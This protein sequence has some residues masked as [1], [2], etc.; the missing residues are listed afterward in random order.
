MRILSML[1]QIMGQGIIQASFTG[2]QRH[3]G[4]TP[5]RKGYSGVKK[6]WCKTH[7]GQS[8][9]MYGYSRR[10]RPVGLT[11]TRFPFSSK[12]K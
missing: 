3:R 9:L 8:L 5:S 1:A 10:Y 6:S 12:K 7:P 2:A 11:K 4:G